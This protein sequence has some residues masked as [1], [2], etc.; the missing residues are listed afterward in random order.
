MSSLSSIWIK[1]KCFSIWESP[2]ET[3]LGL[4]ISCKRSLPHSSGSSMKLLCLNFLFWVSPNWSIFYFPRKLCISSRFSN[5]FAYSYAHI[6]LLIFV[7]FSL[8]RPFSPSY[9]LCCCKYRLLL[10]VLYNY[11]MTFKSCLTQLF[12]PLCQQ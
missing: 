11:F 10:F 4:L 7:M 8:R 6:S 12:I 5:F 2:S 9:G 1:K 3:I